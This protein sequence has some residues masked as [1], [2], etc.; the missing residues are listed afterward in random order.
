MK[1]RKR[2]SPEPESKQ[3]KDQVPSLNQN[4]DDGDGV[5]PSTED[6]N[7]IA[8]ILSNSI[9]KYSV[10][11]KSPT[12]R[13]LEEL[14]KERNF[15]MSGKK[16]ELKARLG[17]GLPSSHI[18]SQTTISIKTK[19]AKPKIS[20]GT[21]VQNSAEPGKLQPPET[22]HR[23]P[24]LKVTLRLKGLRPASVPEP[25]NVYEKEDDFVHEADDE[26]EHFLHTRHRPRP[27][28]TISPQNTSHREEDKLQKF[29]EMVEIIG[30]SLL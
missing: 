26:D 5:G 13:K 28:A 4:Q 20:E 24:S 21:V 12:L 25:V 6:Q 14:C 17:L 2:S 7:E 29:Q 19:G 16:D 18:Q 11:T 30:Q 15:K 9:A 10:V 22:Q 1:T 23:L 3:E 8:T 27:G